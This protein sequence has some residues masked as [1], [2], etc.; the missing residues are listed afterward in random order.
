MRSLLEWLRSTDTHPLIS[1]AVFHYELEFIHSF[2]DGNGR[3]GRLWQTL[4]LSQWR[5]LFVDLPVESLIR[6]RQADY[7]QVLA[8]CGAS[9]ESTAFVIFML[10]LILEG[11]NED[12]VS[13]HVSDHVTRLLEVLQG[14][15]LSVKELMARLRL[16]HRPGF[17]ARY[18]R[19]AME[20]GLVEMTLPDTPRARQ[21]RYR[22]VSREP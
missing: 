16:T 15:P 10:E 20:A 18:L 14:G 4:I 1:S 11:L 19:P 3:L 12:H 6:A 17:R 5:P 8:S 21:Q 22:L 7:Y 9:G 13:D 2:E